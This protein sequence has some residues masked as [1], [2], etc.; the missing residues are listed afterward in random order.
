MLDALA[1]FRTQLPCVFIYVYTY[2]DNYEEAYRTLVEIVKVYMY[3]EEEEVKGK[4]EEKPEEEEVEKEKSTGE[5]SSDSSL[6]GVFLFSVFQF[7]SRFKDLKYLFCERTHD[8]WLLGFKLPGIT[9]VNLT[10]RPA[11]HLYIVSP[12]LFPI[13]AICI[14]ATYA[15]GIS[16]YF[17]LYLDSLDEILS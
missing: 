2:L 13:V 6:R 5:S 17:S 10:L 1:L 12:S 16:V 3:I 4:E 15:N 8:Y 14:M 7:V 9:L 11:T